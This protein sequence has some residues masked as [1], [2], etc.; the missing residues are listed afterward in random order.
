MSDLWTQWV[1]YDAFISENG[2][3][4]STSPVCFLGCSKPHLATTLVKNP[5]KM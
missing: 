2:E 4:L 5:P 1:K 3:M